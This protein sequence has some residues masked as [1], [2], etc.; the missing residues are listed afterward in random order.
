M[1]YLKA[2]CLWLGFLLAAIACGIIREQFLV[3]ALGPL[4]GRAVATLLVG[5]IVF[6]LIYAYIGKLT[7]A[8][9]ASLVKLG[10]CWTMAAIAFEFLFGHYVMG[11]S[12][13]SLCAD[14]NVFQGKL[15]PLVLIVT[16]LGPLWARRIRDYVHVRQPAGN[17]RPQ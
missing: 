5:V 4:A 9:R 14:Y 11:H 1:N 13:L 6:G 2:A 7:G 8:T 16:L 17:F 3:P 15:W 12:W 10:C